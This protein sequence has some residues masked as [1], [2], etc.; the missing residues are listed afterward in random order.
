MCVDVIECCFIVNIPNKWF[1]ILILMT[2]SIPWQYAWPRM[3]WCHCLPPDP[4]T[5]FRSNLKFDQYLECS[6]LTYAQLVTT[7]FFHIMWHEQN[8]IVIS[9]VY[10]KPEH[11]KFWLNF[12][13]DSNIVSGT[14]ARFTICLFSASCETLLNH[15]GHLNAPLLTHINPW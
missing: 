7:N 5:G 1:L 12:E 4:L 2:R 3:P 10:C 13:F 9:W 14:D 15:V 8:F 6:S 11:C